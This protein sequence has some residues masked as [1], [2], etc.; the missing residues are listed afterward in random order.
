MGSISYAW[1]LTRTTSIW[2]VKSIPTQDSWDGAAE[3]RFL[4]PG[5][6][7]EAWGKDWPR[8][9]SPQG[10]PDADGVEH[11][12]RRPGQDIGQPAVGQ[13]PPSELSKV[14]Q[15]CDDFAGWLWREQHA[16]PMCLFISRYN[17]C[18]CF[19]FIPICFPQHPLTIAWLLLQLTSMDFLDWN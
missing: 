11:F 16:P 10:A 12:L 5:S 8:Y 7:Q 19:G 3:V 18:F 13:Q 6:P 2:G 4:T 9:H 1:M 15:S 14:H 17:L